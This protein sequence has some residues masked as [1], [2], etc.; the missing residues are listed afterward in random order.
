MGELTPTH[1]FTRQALKH[2][3]HKKLMTLP[4]K[5]EVAAYISIFIKIN[6]QITVAIIN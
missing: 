1:H 5:A 6:H 2:I 3:K 4:S